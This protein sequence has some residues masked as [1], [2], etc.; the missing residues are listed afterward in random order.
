MGAL[1]RDVSRVPCRRPLLLV[2]LVVLV[3]HEHGIEARTRRPCRGPR[4]DRD[5]APG[6]GAGPVVW[7]Q[8]GRHALRAQPTGQAR[9]HRVVRREHERF[10][11]TGSVAYEREEVGRGGHAPDLDGVRGTW[12]RCRDRIDARAHDPWG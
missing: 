2:G 12:P 1:D 3:Q 7:Q 11:R 5:A 9:R 8:R 6:R 10:A 4:A